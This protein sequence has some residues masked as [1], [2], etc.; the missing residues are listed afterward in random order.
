MMRLSGPSLLLLVA[1]VVGG[2]IAVD[3]MEPSAAT[4]RPDPV[5]AG[6][7]V[8]G[9]WYCAAGAVGE[10]DDLVVVTAASTAATDPA[11]AEI[12]ALHGDRTLVASHPVFP[13]SARRTVVSGDLADG[14]V[15]VAARWW[16]RPVVASRV[17]R[18]S[19]PD[20]VAG[21]VSGPCA[22][23][24]SPTWYVAGVSTADGGT[25]RLYLANPFATDASVAVSFTTPTGLQEP[26]RLQNVSVGARSVI[27]LELNEFIPRE[28]DLGIVVQ[29][30]S[31]RVVAEAVQQLD[32]AIGGVN[33]RALVRA[34]PQL[35]ET[36][37]IPWSLMDPVTFTDDEIADP[38]P[39]DPAP[40]PDEPDPEAPGQGT[41]G[42]EPD[43]DSSII[44]TASPGNGTTSWL[45]VS[46]PSSDAA[47]VTLTL[48]TEVGPVV[49][50]IGDE[51]L[52]EP[53]RITRIDL[54]GLLPSGVSAAGA[55]LRSE[56]G[57]PIVA[58]I[59]TL[60]R[61]DVTDPSVTGYTSQLGWPEPDTSWVIPG[62]APG[63]RRQVIHV[64]NPGA[65]TAVVNVALWNGAVLSRP[66]ALQGVEVSPGRLIEFLVS[67]VVSGA[68]HMV[69]YVDSSG[70][71]VVAGRHSVG[72]SPVE[73]IAHTGVPSALWSG[74]AIVPAVNHDPYLL[75]R[76]G[77]VGDQRPA[78]DDVDP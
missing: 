5:E 2:I 1:V 77:T 30:R 60:L 28:P 45:W 47:A 49:P 75:E 53:G 44:A 46:N 58:S 22:T 21:T 8:A 36:W 23:A 13:G 52:I 50:D 37:T 31:G 6:P 54:R 61:P 70:A 18:S 10:N 26:I 71:P 40:A 33:G 32:A 38:E 11:D 63:T 4:S 64:V 35:A 42:P 73:W 3:L 24:P 67:D 14:P 20:G 41:D 59:S 48:H 72:G 56:N 12:S 69:A 51:I 39:D 62:E 74:G 17:W 57:V 66:A 76:L 65:D 78:D 19:P 29:A 25:A 7:A 68:T 16:E 15:G 55:T 34:A 43:A 27:E 9:A